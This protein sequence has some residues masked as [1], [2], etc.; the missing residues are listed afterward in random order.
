MSKRGQLATRKRPLAWIQQH[1]H[2]GRR[3]SMQ[4]R[5]AG[6]PCDRG[7]HCEAAQAELAR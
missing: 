1:Q 3:H 5:S 2:H 6:A 4:R 7:G